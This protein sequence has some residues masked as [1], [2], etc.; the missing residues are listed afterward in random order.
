MMTSAPEKIPATPIPATARPTI[1]TVL[2]GAT[3]HINDPSSK[4]KTAHRNAHFAYSRQT[5]Q[6]MCL[7]KAVKEGEGEQ[8]LNIL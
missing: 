1:R 6:P 7:S 8:T 2:D 3:A 5:N 4:R